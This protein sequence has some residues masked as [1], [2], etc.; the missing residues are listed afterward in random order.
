MNTIGFTHVSLG[1]HEFDFGLKILT[2][3]LKESQF[4][5][6]NTNVTGLDRMIGVEKNKK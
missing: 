2:Q 4:T 1:N 5:V 6:L 3:R